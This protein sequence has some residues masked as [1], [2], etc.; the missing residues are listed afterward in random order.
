MPRQEKGDVLIQ[1]TTWVGLTFFL[2]KF[3]NTGFKVEKA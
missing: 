2:H 3:Y 1:V